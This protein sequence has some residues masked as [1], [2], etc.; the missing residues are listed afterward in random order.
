M[1]R[2][3]FPLFPV[4]VPRGAWKPQAGMCVPELC[5]ETHTLQPLARACVPTPLPP[6]WMSTVCPLRTPATSKM[7]R[8]AVS[9]VSM[10]PAASWSPKDSGTRSTEPASTHTWTAE[11]LLSPQGSYHPQGRCAV[12]RE[13]TEKRGTAHVRALAPLKILVSA[14][15][16]SIPAAAQKS[17]YPLPHLERPRRHLRAYLQPHGVKAAAW[18]N[19]PSFLASNVRAFHVK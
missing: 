15:L 17:H 8:Y 7:F 2:F 3:H 9:V 16:L 6:P 13:A 10:K 4:E 19:I 1:T 18:A 14:H 12:R 5:I 11:G